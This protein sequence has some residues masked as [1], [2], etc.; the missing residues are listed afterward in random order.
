MGRERRAAGVAG[1]LI[2]VVGALVAPATAAGADS[3]PAVTVSRVSSASPFA[4]GD[5]GS[6]VTMEPHGVEVG[7]AFAVAGHGLV[8]AWQQDG[9]LGT[10]AAAS[11]HDGGESWTQV[12]PPAT[13]VCNGGTFARVGTPVLAV[14]GAGT[15]ILVATPGGPDL[16][17]GLEASRSADGGAT[18]SAPVQLLPPAWPPAT[19]PVISPDPSN[20]HAA[21]VMFVTVPAL[22]QPWV[23]RTTD[24]GQT[25]SPPVPAGVA[26]PERAETVGLVTQ[27]DGTLVDVAWS[28]P[29]DDARLILGM[30]TV[31]PT[32]CGQTAPDPTPCTT[33]IHARR[34][35]D[36]GATWTDQD[37]VTLPDMHFMNETANEPAA[38]ALGPDGSV[39][40]L[41]PFDDAAGRRWTLYGSPDGVHW[42]DRG[43][44]VPVD[45][46]SYWAGTGPSLAVAPDGSI[47]VL[48]SDHVDA[49]APQA[50]CSGTTTSCLTEVRLA[51]SRD[52]KAW[53]SVRLGG[54]FDIDQVRGA[55]VGEYV[56]LRP[57]DDGLGAVFSLGPC[58]AAAG[59]GCP[60]ALDGP[61]DVFFAHVKL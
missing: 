54:P 46:D 50:P 45:S 20:P 38:P 59:P 2:F 48:T 18:W 29:T 28:V 13:T 10:V 24:D 53:N 14:D 19:E 58:A 12:E 47:G 55:W 1:A 6:D 36:H 34:S 37:I 30:V 44:A 22:G 4:P 15:A 40:V 60:S 26:A 43:M 3:A 33:K 27:A 9:G 52:G 35:T 25:W 16:H 23:T 49:A 7:P 8:A 42:S 61:T 41:I 21:T 56:D 17:G 32:N 31:D 39:N 5:C 51:Y 57:V 11:P